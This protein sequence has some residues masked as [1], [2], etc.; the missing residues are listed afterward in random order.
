MQ[1]HRLR[2]P[3]V[4]APHHHGT[5]R[6]AAGEEAAAGAEAAAV[7]AVAV[8]RQGREGE[9]REVGR[10]VDAQRFIDGAGRQEGGR[11][12]AAAELVRV[13]PEGADQRHH[14]VTALPGRRFAHKVAQNAQICAGEGRPV[15]RRGAAGRAEEDGVAR[16]VW[17]PP[18]LGT[19][20]FLFSVAGCFP[21]PVSARI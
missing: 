15:G 9:L 17:R 1:Q 14:F 21:R 12:G 11:E 2:V 7:N 20:W 10:V 13:V 16:V 6:G 5:V 3:R 18:T 8:A 19:T 4:R